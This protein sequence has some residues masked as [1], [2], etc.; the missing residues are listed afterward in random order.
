[1]ERFAHT[2]PAKGKYLVSSRSQE[3]R[4]YPSHGELRKRRLGSPENMWFEPFASEKKSS[5][6]VEPHLTMVDKEFQFGPVSTH[7]VQWYRLRTLVSLFVVVILTWSPSPT[8]S[9]CTVSTQKLH[10]NGP[11]ISRGTPCSKT[12]FKFKW[13][14]LYFRLIGAR[15]FTQIDRCRGAE[16]RALW[17]PMQNPNGNKST[18]HG[19]DLSIHKHAC[20]CYV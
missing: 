16:W 13:N 5:W 2:I 11:L 20:M 18:S 6:F 17:I 15:S 10:T 9:C 4:Y 7:S 3:V 8:Y 1:M 14:S 19:T 12:Q